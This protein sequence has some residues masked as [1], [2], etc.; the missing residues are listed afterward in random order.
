M[1]LD[2][3]PVMDKAQALY[4]SFGFQPID[5]YYPNP[6]PGTVFMEL[7]LTG[8]QQSGGRRR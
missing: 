3:L 8:R 7:D 2:T 4:R 1:R 5:P 6:V